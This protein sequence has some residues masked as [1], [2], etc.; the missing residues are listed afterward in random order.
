MDC[1]ALA[2]RAELVA[3]PW[4][5]ARARRAAQAAGFN[6]GTR[7]R[8]QGLRGDRREGHRAQQADDPQEGV[9]QAPT[10]CAGEDQRRP[11]WR[12]VELHEDSPMAARV[13]QAAPRRSQKGRDRGHEGVAQQQAKRPAQPVKGSCQHH[14]DQSKARRSRTQEAKGQMLP[15][16]LNRPLGS[17]MSI[18]QQQQERCGQARRRQAKETRWQSTTTRAWRPQQLPLCELRRA[19]A[20]RPRLQE[21]KAEEE[22]LHLRQRPAPAGRLPTAKWQWPAQSRRQQQR[23]WEASGRKESGCQE[24][25]N[26]QVIEGEAQVSGQVCEQQPQRRHDHP[27]HRL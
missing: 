3:G 17:T 23:S 14:Q 11:Q 13:V 9:G 18:S 22:V 8:H 6:H 24:G 5:A 20:L 4:R 25:A 2:H 15:V 16:W 26:H 27:L 21:A 1:Q 19:R 10:A 7:S 12:G